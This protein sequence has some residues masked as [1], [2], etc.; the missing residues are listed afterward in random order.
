[1]YPGTASQY[2]SVGGNFGEPKHMRILLLF[3]AI[4]LS[5]S[6]ESNI[7]MHSMK[8]ISIAIGGCSKGCE[9]SIYEVDSSMKTRHTCIWNCCKKGLSSGTISKR[10]WD[11]I[12]S[13][14]NKIKLGNFNYENN[15]HDTS[16]YVNVKLTTKGHQYHIK[17]NLD[18]LPSELSDFLKF[19]ILELKQVDLVKSTDKNDL[20]FEVQVPME[21]YY[22]LP[23]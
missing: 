10:A 21:N 3:F 13:N 8:K 18:S 5:C 20:N 2:L 11:S 15:I 19:T 7:E 22:K 4:I 9:F 1:L 23:Y 17:G 12:S 6:C 14:A 16:L